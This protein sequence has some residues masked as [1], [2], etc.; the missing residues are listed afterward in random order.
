MHEEGISNPTGSY[1]VGADVMKQCQQLARDIQQQQQQRQ[2]QQQ[3]T[4]D[5]DV[6]RCATHVF[7]VNHD[8]THA[9]H[10]LE[11]IVYKCYVQIMPFL[12]L[13]LPIGDKRRIKSTSAVFDSVCL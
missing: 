2:H 9:F 3:H 5:P 8:Y 4:T 6:A 10:S 11:L 7:D 12:C 13:C 1:V